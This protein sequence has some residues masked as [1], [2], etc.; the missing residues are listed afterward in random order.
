MASLARIDAHKQFTQAATPIWRDS[1]G[2]APV[3][4]ASLARAILLA[5]VTCARKALGAHDQQ[6][7]RRIKKAHVRAAIEAE[8][9][10]R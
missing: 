2:F 1:Y 6:R 9:A 7:A 4:R 3:P 10:G 8:L 5:S